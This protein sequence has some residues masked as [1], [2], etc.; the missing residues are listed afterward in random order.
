MVLG[1]LSKLQS[2]CLQFANRQSANSHKSLSGVELDCCCTLLFRRYRV[3][4]RHDADVAVRIVSII[5]AFLRAACWCVL[6]CVM[7]ATQSNMGCF[8]R[9]FFRRAMMAR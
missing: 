6:V 8:C 4:V 9:A 5:P 1:M 3:V 7:L 2:A